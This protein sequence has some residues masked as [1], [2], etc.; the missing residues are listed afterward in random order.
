MS[1]CRWEPRITVAEGRRWWECIRCG[2]T[3]E[4]EV[5]AAAECAAQSSDR[6]D[7]PAHYTAHP[8]GVECIDI[9]QHMNFCLGNVVKYC[10]RADLKGNDVED[11]AKAKRY[12]E[13]EIKRR[14][15]IA[16][17]DNEGGTK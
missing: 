7:H 8:S 5:P 17:R 15:A 2:R 12:L 1:L 4:S 14:Q 10:W 9:V 3:Q 6:V 13:Y 11:L 16:E